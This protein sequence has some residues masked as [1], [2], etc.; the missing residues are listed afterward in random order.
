MNRTGKIMKE[1]VR[2][3]IWVGVFCAGTALVEYEMIRFIGSGIVICLTACSLAAVI[4]AL[5]RAPHGSEGLDGLE[6]EQGAYPFCMR[7]VPLTSRL[8]ATRLGVALRLIIHT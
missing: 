7:A 4:I 6:L 8:S 1:I 2:A 3:S 5:F